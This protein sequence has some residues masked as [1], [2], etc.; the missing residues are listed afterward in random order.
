MFD[1]LSVH[2]SYWLKVGVSLN[3]SV[4]SLRFASSYFE[5][6]Q[7]VTYVVKEKGMK[8]KGEQR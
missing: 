3:I 7:I 4:V 5:V 2:L 1:L 8:Y 6:P